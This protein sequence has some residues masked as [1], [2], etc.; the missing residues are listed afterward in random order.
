MPSDVLSDMPS[1]APSASLSE[2]PS[3]VAS[4]EPSEP[5]SLSPS[6]SP[7]DSPSESP[8]ESPSVSPSLAFS[9]NPSENPSATPSELP[10]ESPSDS[11]SAFPS[12]AP[13]NSPSEPPS[14]VPTSSPSESPSDNP[15]NP[16]SEPP[17]QLPSQAPSSQPS[18]AP[19]LTVT[20]DENP[21]VCNSG[22]M[23]TVT[24]NNVQGALTITLSAAGNAFADLQ[25][26]GFN[27]V[28]ELLDGESS[29]VYTVDIISCADQ[30][31]TVTVSADGFESGSVDVLATGNACVFKKSCNRRFLQGQLLEEDTDAMPS[32]EW[33]QHST[34][35]FQTYPHLVTPQD[36][37][38]LLA[39]ADKLANEQQE[40]EVSVDLTPQE[41]SSMVSE[42]SLRAIYQAFHDFSPHPIQIFRLRRT[43][44][45]QA[46]H[47]DYHSDGDNVVMQI[48]L[49]NDKGGQL[50]YRTDH[51]MQQ[52]DWPRYG[53]VIHAPHV[54]H[55]LSAFEGLKVTLTVVASVTK[56]EE[57]TPWESY[58]ASLEKSSIDCE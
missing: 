41:L 19:A 28:A 29:F 4:E 54:V 47:M 20:I 43:D 7:I 21:V 32:Q 6:E 42:S 10:S 18:D 23:V 13:S 48:K 16:P 27:P 15:S 52:A 2:M 50:Q 39:Y 26:T 33:E 11:P 22:N 36:A 3:D 37:E 46:H 56:E 35:P 31:V 1:E 17:S 5:P 14:E 58:L 53:A 49:T 44:F 57:S 55:G 12:E 51:G 34:I 45:L 24:R 30:T 9:D 40:L 38:A 8:S 25:G